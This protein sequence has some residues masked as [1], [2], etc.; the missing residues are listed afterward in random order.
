ME[1][2]AYVAECNDEALNANEGMVSDD[3]C[4]KRLQTRDANS[5]SH[6]KLS[7]LNDAKVLSRSIR[8]Y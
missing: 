6:S 1:K 2:F 4:A 7:C 3:I 5:L 8:L